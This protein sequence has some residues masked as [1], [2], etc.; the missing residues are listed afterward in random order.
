MIRAL[1]GVEDTTAE[2]EGEKLCW[3]TCKAS[4]K[5]SLHRNGNYSAQQSDNK[6]LSP[7]PPPHKQPTK[8]NHHPLS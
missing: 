5:L 8:I 7:A 4:L 1:I 6:L 2:M 3:S